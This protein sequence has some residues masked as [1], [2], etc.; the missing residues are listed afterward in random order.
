MNQAESKPPGRKLRWFWRGFVLGVVVILLGPCIVGP[1][2]RGPIASAIEDELFASASIDSL[3][4]SILGTASIEGIELTHLDGKPLLSIE[5]ID[6][7]ADL[8]SSLGGRHDVEVEI[9]GVTVYAEQR[10]DGSIDLLEL[11]RNPSDEESELPE[12]RAKVIVHDA[13]LHMTTPDGPIELREGTLDLELRTFDELATFVAKGILDEVPPGLLPFQIDA[14]SE[15]TP[16][17]VRGSAKVETAPQ[18]FSLSDFELVT[19]FATVQG[20][21]QLD[22]S[23]AERATLGLSLDSVG[24]NA[25]LAGLLARVHPIF[26]GLEK[27]S[28]GALGGSVSTAVQV[29]WDGAFDVA[30]LAEDPLSLLQLPLSGSGSLALSDMKLSGSPL[31]SSLLGYLGVDSNE[32]IDMNQMTFNIEDGG[33]SYA[34]PWTWTIAGIETSFTGGVSFDQGLDLDWNVPIT[35]TLTQRYELLDSFQG[36]ILR[37]PLDGTVEAPKVRWTEAI[38]GLAKDAL[39][40]GLADKVGLGDLGDLG[41]LAGLGIGGKD[42]KDEAGESAEELYKRANKLWDEGDKAAAALLYKRIRE[43]H[44]LS[45]TYT[46][47]RKRIKD[48]EDWKPE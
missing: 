1:F 22:A 32:G 23:G 37:V 13:A 5:E 29:S 26:S 41:D 17:E 45:L 7:D 30:A 42:K 6:A 21:T 28:G 4:L 3:R 31:A 9:R 15:A 35:K 40:G 12:M 47:N 38:T 39:T 33:L 11:Q 8:F 43:D 46:L 16:V 44:K 27:A 48:R 14:L 24:G 10:E 25:Q 19:P 34:N 18:K 20:G 36:E 2:A